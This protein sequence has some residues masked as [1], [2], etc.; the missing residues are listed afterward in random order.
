M[1]FDR[2][3]D[4]DTLIIHNK[5]DTA[6]I[7]N[8]GYGANMED[9][10]PIGHALGTNFD[11]YFP[12][13][14]VDLHRE[15]GQYSQGWFPLDMNILEKAF[16]TQE[17]SPLL[18]TYFQKGFDRA[19][20]RVGKFV[21][22]VGKHYRRII[23]GGFSQGAMVAMGVGFKYQH[24]VDK[25]L[26][27]SGLFIS[28]K[29]WQGY[30]GRMDSFQSHGKRDILLPYS[31]GEALCQFLLSHNP[32]HKFVSHEGGHEIPSSILKEVR[33]FLDCDA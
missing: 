28:E 27:F 17:F 8:H 2:I 26:I 15:F 32:K 10:V 19:Q 5:S 29:V 9:L 30:N 3:E 4:L 25:L 24:I 33:E 14:F 21:T 7:L 18:N 12:N 6:V 13:G 20:Q 1:K 31:Q 16:R 11:W 23:L 22:N